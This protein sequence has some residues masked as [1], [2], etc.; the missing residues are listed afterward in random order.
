MR[1]DIKEIV[2]RE[3]EGNVIFLYGNEVADR[4]LPLGKK[5]LEYLKILIDLI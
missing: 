4:V 2:A 1:F 5:E 3:Y